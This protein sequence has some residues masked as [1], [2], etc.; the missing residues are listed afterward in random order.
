MKLKKIFLFTTLSISLLTVFAANGDNN[1]VYSPETKPTSIQ[2][3]IKD[4]MTGE[5]LAGVSIKVEGIEKTYFSDFNGNYCV[6]DIEPGKYT[7]TYSYISYQT[8]TEEKIEIKEN[9]RYNM[10]LSMDIIR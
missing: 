6:E 8:I 5:L 7:I 4:A 10:D 9:E 2:G 1:E 3:I